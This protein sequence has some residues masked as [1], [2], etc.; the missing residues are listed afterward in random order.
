[1]AF[2]VGPAPFPPTPTPHY[3]SSTQACAA[4]KMGVSLPAAFPMAMILSKKKQDAGISNF[5]RP[6]LH[7]FYSGQPWKAKKEIANKGPRGVTVY[8]GSQGLC[9]CAHSTLHPLRSNQSKTWDLLK[10]FPKLHTDSSQSSGSFTG[11]RVFLN[12]LLSKY[13]LNDNLLW[14]RASS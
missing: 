9:P 13:W 3:W 10:A 6:L 5:P 4:K 12:M 14:L 11:T 8:P 1:M 2:E 7:K